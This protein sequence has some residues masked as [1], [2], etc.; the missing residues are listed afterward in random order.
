MTTDVQCQACAFFKRTC[1]KCRAR[2]IEAARD[3]VIDWALHAV[4]H[5]E[6]P[7]HMGLH[8][9]IQAYRQ[10]TGGDR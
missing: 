3:R 9:A 5:G 4:E 10:L 6:H 1:S 2:E 8:Q 7:Q